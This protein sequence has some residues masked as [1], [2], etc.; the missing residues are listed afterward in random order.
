MAVEE[1]HKNDI[2]TVLK[3]TMLDGDAIVSLAAASVKKI[4]LRK[5]SGDVL[6]KSASLFTDGTDGIMTYTTIADD[7][8]ETGE[9]KIQAYV[10]I[11]G[12]WHSSTHTFRVFPNLN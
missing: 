12:H 11:S 5:P 1:I 2:G 10:E 8:D 3:V 9:W 4:L 6:E 7:L